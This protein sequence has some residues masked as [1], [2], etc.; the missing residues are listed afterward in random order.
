M[1]SKAKLG[2]NI[3]EGLISTVAR[4]YVQ[5]S[6]ASTNECAIAIDAQGLQAG[7]EA[8][9]LTTSASTAW[10]TSKHCS[11]ICQAARVVLAA[12]PARQVQLQAQVQARWTMT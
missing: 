11:G 2:E 4:T 7:E 9:L 12:F 6:N 8:I 1:T 10:T 5:T 3:V